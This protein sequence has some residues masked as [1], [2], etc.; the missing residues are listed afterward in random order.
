MKISDTHRTIALLL[1]MAIWS[2]TGCSDNSASFTKIESERAKLING[3]ESYQQIEEFTHFLNSRSV[4]WKQIEGSK[5]DFQ[6]GRPPFNIDSIQIKNYCHHGFCGELYI[7]F[8]ND[9]LWGTL[10]YPISLEKYI[11]ALKKTEGIHFDEKNE[12][13][14]PPHTRIRLGVDIERRKYV[15]WSDIRLDNEYGVLTKY[16]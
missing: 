4:E 11:E 14:I 1:M 15:R 16:S 8:F 9:R 12:V 3:I 7:S 2:L 5:Q 13:I 6:S 10:F